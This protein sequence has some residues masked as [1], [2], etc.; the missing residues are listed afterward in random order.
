MQRRR[1]LGVALVIVAI[2]AIIMARLVWI[3]GIAWRRY[4]V[5]AE[6]VRRTVRFTSAPRGRI[7]DR[8]GRVLAHD[9]PSHDIVY[10]LREVEFSH[11]V[12][13][14]LTEILRSSTGEFP[15]DFDSLQGSLW[16]LRLR[17][18]ARLTEDESLPSH[19]WLTALDRGIAQRLDARIRR[20]PATQR[21]W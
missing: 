4:H 20:N 19:R 13:R 1:V 16:E 9:V 10:T 3:Q 6:N 18:G 11:L 8:Y 5:N 12:V 7:V 2:F 17:Y 14:R 21:L 15:Y